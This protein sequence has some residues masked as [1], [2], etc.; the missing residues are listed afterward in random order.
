MN[1]GNAFSECIMCPPSIELLVQRRLELTLLYT[2]YNLIRN[3]GFNQ[4]NFHQEQ[5]RIDIY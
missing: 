4:K 1:N 2:F 5:I 3:S